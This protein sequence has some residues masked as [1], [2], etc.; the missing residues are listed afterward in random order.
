MKAILTSGAGILVILFAAHAL[1]QP[2]AA[3]LA[4]TPAVPPAVPNVTAPRPAE[5]APISVAYGRPSR[6]VRLRNDG[7]LVGRVMGPDSVEG[8]KPVRARVALAQNGQ[9]V[10]SVRSDETGYFQISGIRPGAYSVFVAGQGGFTAFAVRVQPFQEQAAVERTAPGEAKFQFA[11]L[12]AAQ[13]GEIESSLDISSLS[14][15]VDGNVFSQVLTEEGLAPPAGAPGMAGGFAPGMGQG[16]GGM[17]G[18]GAGA[19]AGGGLGLG[20]LL[21]A[22]GMGIG[23]GGIGGQSGGGQPPASEVVPPTE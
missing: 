20:G 3:P 2:A 23:L 14:P 1:A 17:G 9:I 6:T 11:N 16:M 7:N 4:P 5:A 18:G 21:G 13:D 12:N 15:S 22:A 10:H 19:G 8:Q